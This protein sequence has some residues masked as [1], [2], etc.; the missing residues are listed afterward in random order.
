MKSPRI[1][2]WFLALCRQPRSLL[3]LT[4]SPVNTRGLRLSMLRWSNSDRPAREE[5]RQATLSHISVEIPKQTLVNQ[6]SPVWRAKAP[7]RSDGATASLWRCTKGTWL[8][9]ICSVAAERRSEVCHRAW[10]Y[11]K[12]EARSSRALLIRQIFERDMPVA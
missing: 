11:R 7:L 3:A 1:R 4:S 12:F 5:M 10:F 8:P 9:R 2:S 6:C